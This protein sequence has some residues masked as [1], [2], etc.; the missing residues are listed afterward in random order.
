[1][2]LAT[3]IIKTLA[4]RSVVKVITL[5]Y[6]NKRVYWF[7]INRHIFSSDYDFQ[8]E[9]KITNGTSSYYVLAIFGDSLWYFQKRNGFSINQVNVS[10]GNIIRS[11]LVDKTYEDIIVFHSYIQ[12]MGM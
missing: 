2:N 10:N 11:I 5:D 8:H 9:K 6:T 12:P 3:N 4:R 7:G 1:M